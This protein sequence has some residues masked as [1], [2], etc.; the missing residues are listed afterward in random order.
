MNLVKI[1]AVQILRAFRSRN[2]RR[3]RRINDHVLRDA[4]IYPAPPNI[5]LAVITYIFSKILAK[6]RFLKRECLP[7]LKNIEAL[8][9][10][11]IR[12][13]R[14]EEE[15]QEILGL[16]EREIEEIEKKD[17]RFLNNLLIKGRLKTAAT[18]YAQGISAGAAA[19]LVGVDKQEVLEYAGQTLM[20]DRMKEAK[21]IAKRMAQ[22]RA[23]LEG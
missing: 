7:C 4:V 22:L 3:M 10:K 23:F 16:I 13:R 6:P 20:A 19:E 12:A 21:P 11:L 17:P 9:N 14:S 2:A 8:L 18:L 15:A 5:K 1:Y